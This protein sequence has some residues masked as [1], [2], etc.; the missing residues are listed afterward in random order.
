[1]ILRELDRRHPCVAHL[2]RCKDTVLIT[3]SLMSSLFVPFRCQDITL[4]H[5]PAMCIHVTEILLLS[6]I[7]MFCSTAGQHKPRLGQV[8]LVVFTNLVEHAIN[9]LAPC[10]AKFRIVL[11][12]FNN[13][14]KEGRHDES[15]LRQI[16]VS[17][18]KSNVGGRVKFLNDSSVRSGA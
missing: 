1:M 9:C 14:Y 5:T 16:F 6:C 12:P 2:L 10:P 13:L 11:V 3:F 8:V 7:P 17:A 15:Q 4:L 18:Y